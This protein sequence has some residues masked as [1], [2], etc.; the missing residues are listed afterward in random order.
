MTWRKRFVD[1]GIVP[2][3]F[4]A[5]LIAAGI[6]FAAVEDAVKAILQI[7]CDPTI[8]GRLFRITREN[9]SIN[10]IT[11]WSFGVLPRTRAPEGYMDL[12]VDD[13]KPTDF[14]YALE[15]MALNVNF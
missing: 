5:K 4:K 8:H 13:L 3:P 15:Q 14:L 1:T 12:D 7:A 11:S 6:E 2:A 10:L 9:K